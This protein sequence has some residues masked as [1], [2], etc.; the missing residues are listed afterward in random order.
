M[1]PQSVFCPNPDCKSRG[2]VGLGNIGIKSQKQRRY[3]CKDC[4]RSFAE[5]SGTPLYGLKKQASLFIIVITLLCHGCPL[6]AIVA[7][8]GFDERTVFA[9]QKK[10]GGHCKQ[11][12]ET[13]V[14]QPR[15]LG[16]VQADEIRVKMANKIITWMA[17]AMQVSTRLWLGGVISVRRDQ[18]LINALA[19]KVKSCAAY[20]AILLVTD[21]LIS[22]VKAWRNAFRTPLYTGKVGRPTLLAWPEVVIGQVI[23][24][25]KARRLLEVERR[26][27]QG[28]Q[29]QQEALQL[30]GQVLNTSYIERLNATFRA[31]L[32][33]LVRRG[34]ALL[35]QQSPLES[36][37]YL[38]GTV[39]NFCGFHHSLRQEQTE[40]RLKWCERT[41]AM[42]AGITDHRW[43]TQELLTYQIAPPPFV[44]PKRRGRRPKTV[45]ALAM[46][47]A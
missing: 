34:R 21:G 42:A 46:V 38:L 23:K 2:R 29:L 47:G 10:A 16:Q 31:S 5:T 30:E 7:A 18:H 24:R 41:P 19:T 40:G 9:W 43:S 44:P 26:L 45:V 6:Q 15:D 8:F 11:V 20:A 36:G 4:N 33:V 1:N 27:V 35:H 3:R 25:H 14:E 17:M 22:Y 32:H 37:M 13:L 28:S 39:Y 12:H